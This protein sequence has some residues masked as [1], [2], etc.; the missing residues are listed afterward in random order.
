MRIA[1]WI[2][3]PLAIV[4]VAMLLG[5]AF[6]VV[7]QSALISAGTAAMGEVI[8]LEPSSGSGGSTRYRPVVRFATPQGQT[9]I[10]GEVASSPPSR[11]HPWPR[12]SRRP[13][14]TPT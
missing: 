8:A 5:A 10:V 13:W 3:V 11:R 2:G 4:G 7:R 14:R 12:R 9:T 1:K 6:V